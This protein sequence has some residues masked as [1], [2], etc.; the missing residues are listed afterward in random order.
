MK[1]S[2]KVGLSEQSTKGAFFRVV[3]VGQSSPAR[4]KN[5]FVGLFEKG[6]GNNFAI[7][8]RENLVKV[9]NFSLW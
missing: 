8:T 6:T 4:L 3:S 9:D 1:Y 2:V 7:F 5:F